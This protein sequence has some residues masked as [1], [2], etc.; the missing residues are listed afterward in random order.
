M[1]QKTKVDSSYG[2]KPYSTSTSIFT[3]KFTPHTGKCTHILPH[4]HIWKE[5]EGKEEGGKEGRK[6]KGKEGRK[7]RKS[8]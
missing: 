3:L 6:E 5:E 2:M 1:S 4:M 8:W 7:M